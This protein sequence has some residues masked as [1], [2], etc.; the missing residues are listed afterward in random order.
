MASF[1]RRLVESHADKRRHSWPFHH[2]PR[3]CDSTAHY[4]LCRVPDSKQEFSVPHHFQDRFPSPASSFRRHGRFGRIRLEAA[5][6]N[7]DR[8]YFFLL[9]SPVSI[10]SHSVV[11][12][13]W[14]WRSRTSKG[15]G[16]FLVSLV[17][18]FLFLFYYTCCGAQKKEQPPLAP[19]T[20]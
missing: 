16:C 17:I 7:I 20:L 15:P 4:R 12:C 2:L 1:Q 5:S 8:R 13:R 14:R 9:A 6:R 10:F 19:R 11:F 18:P 3:F